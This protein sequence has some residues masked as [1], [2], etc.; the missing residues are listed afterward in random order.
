MDKALLKYFISKANLTTADLA[1]KLNMSVK[2]VQ[3]KLSGRTEFTASEI[4]GLIEVCDLSRDD[5]C[6]IFFNKSV[7]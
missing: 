2:T 1:A 6:H 4:N 7:A 5:L 3:N